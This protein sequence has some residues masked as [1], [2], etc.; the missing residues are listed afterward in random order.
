MKH[1]WILAVGA[2]L[3]N[4]FVFG[5]GDKISFGPEIDDLSEVE[6]FVRFQKAVTRALKQRKAS[7]DV[8]AY[9]L[10]P[11]YF[12]CQHA[13]ELGHLF[14][15]AKLV[16]VQHHQ[17][18]IASVM[19]E[20]GLRKPVLGIAFDGTGYGSDGKIWG[21]EFLAVNRAKFSRLAHFKYQP[22]PGGE[23]VVYEPWRMVLS[24]LGVKGLPFVSAKNKTA[25]LT[26][27]QKNIHC[28][29]SSSVGRL[30]DAAA[31]LLGV[32]PVA[33]F[34]AEGPIKLEA[35]CRQDVDEFYPINVERSQGKEIIDPLPMFL[36]MGRDLRK[37]KEASFIATKFHNTIANVTI[38]LARA[39][40]RRLRSKD[41]VLSG[42][43]FQN[44]YL[45][46][47]IMEGLRETGCRVFTNEKNSVN[48]FNIALGQYHVSRCSWPN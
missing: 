21:G 20:Y 23:K 42:G 18:H 13:R 14:P 26:M 24:I 6:N 44:V 27:I 38:D 28:P 30:F 1:H 37:R 40:T 11:N 2:D 25:V 45:R 12:S 22:M 8:I 47:K 7:P 41:I 9:D 3:K 35:M 32:C 46:T 43:V 10:H 19:S 31:A 4:Q 15:R 34:E 5:Q 33:R 39:L 16:G 29:N 17:A 48:D 36:A